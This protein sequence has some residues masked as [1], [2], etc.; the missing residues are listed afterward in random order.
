M[1]K[2][3]TQ[4]TKK[5]FFILQY[6]TLESTVVQ[7]D[8]WNPGAGIEWTGTKSYYWR[9]ERRWEMVELKGRQQTGDAG[10]AATSLTPDA[11]GP[12]DCTFESSQLEG[13]YQDVGDLL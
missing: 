11:D 7:Y 6:G 13:L 5:A 9:Q 1:H 10:P 12:H 8:S 3:Q 2:R 4:K